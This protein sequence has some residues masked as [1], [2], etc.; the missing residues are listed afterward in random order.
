ME[1]FLKILLGHMGE[2]KDKSEYI[3]FQAMNLYPVEKLKVAQVAN[4]VGKKSRSNLL[5]AYRYKK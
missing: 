4:I 5:W 1:V 3:K 2:A